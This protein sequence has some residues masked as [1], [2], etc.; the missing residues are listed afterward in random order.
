MRVRYKRIVVPM[1]CP[2]EGMADTALL[3]LTTKGEMVLHGYDRDVDIAAEALGLPVSPCFIIEQQWDVIIVDSIA[4]PQSMR[5]SYFEVLPQKVMQELLRVGPRIKEA[6]E[7]AYYES[8]YREPSSR[9]VDRAGMSFKSELFG[10]RSAVQTSVSGTPE[11]VWHSKYGKRQY[12][13]VA[14]RV[15]LVTTVP[16]YITLLNKIPHGVVF[17]PKSKTWCMAASIV[18]VIDRNSVVVVA[19]KQG[20]GVAVDSRRALVQKGSDGSWVVKKWL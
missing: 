13:G 20:R 11:K 18:K 6:A 4:R 3:E 10:P 5:S 19:G 2:E 16:A 8:T 12:S 15:T 7:E 1:H 9:W 14:V 17:D